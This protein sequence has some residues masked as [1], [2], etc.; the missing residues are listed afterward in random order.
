MLDDQRIDGQDVQPEAAK[1]HVLWPSSPGVQL[2]QGSICCRCVLC[3][4]HCNN[5]AAGIDSLPAQNTANR[6][7]QDLHPRSGAKVRINKEVC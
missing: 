7:S 6:A 1:L 4:W 2:E 5:V 3:K